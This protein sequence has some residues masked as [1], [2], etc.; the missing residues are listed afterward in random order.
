MIQ[1]HSTLRL[2]PNRG[3]YMSTNPHYNFRSNSHQSRV[4]K[5]TKVLKE[6]GKSNHK[7]SI[8]ILHTSSKQ[9]HESIRCKLKAKVSGRCFLASTKTEFRLNRQNKNPIRKL[10]GNQQLDWDYLS[11]T[12]VQ[13]S[14][15]SHLKTSSFPNSKSS[16]SLTSWQQSETAPRMLRRPSSL[17]SSHCPSSAA[18]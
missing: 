1:Y 7:T 17:L 6:Q 2:S 15:N 5:I 10:L 8:G 3:A 11:H 14:M 9:A 13:H 16:S 4:L 18:H 12:L